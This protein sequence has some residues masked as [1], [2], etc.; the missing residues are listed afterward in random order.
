[1][2]DSYAFYT[3]QLKGEYQEAFH[4]IEIYM[5]GMEYRFDSYEERLMELLDIFLI[6]QEKGRPVTSI[7]GKDM[8][9]FCRNFCEGGSWQ[10]VLR[11]AAEFF[12]NISWWLLILSVLELFFL[13]PDWEWGSGNLF[14]AATELE[15]GSWLIGFCIAW[16]VLRSFQAIVREIM[17]KIRHFSWRLYFVVY[18]SLT[19]VLIVGLSLF[20]SYHEIGVAAVP[21]IP[22]GLVSGGYLLIYYFCFRR[23]VQRG[24]AHRVR[25][26][27]LVRANIQED[28]SFEGQLT[29]SMHKQLERKNRRRRRRGKDEWDWE[30]YLSYLERDEKTTRNILKLY[31]VIPFLMADFFTFLSWSD[32]ESVTLQ[33]LGECYLMVFLFFAVVYGIIYLILRIPFKARWEWIHRQRELL[34]RPNDEKER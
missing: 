1:M 33:E 4:Q 13:L 8:E 18:F 5:A 34:E 10:G 19:A 11:R 6:A 22:M 17:F 32:G 14:L 3:D 9:Q 2:K 26:M 15:I 31:V 23:K 12:W 28:V 24:E 21:I 16:A 27:D 7:T 25:F 20:Y 29:Q 30:D